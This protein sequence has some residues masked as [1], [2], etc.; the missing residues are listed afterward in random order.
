DIGGGQL[1]SGM[2]LERLHE[3]GNGVGKPSGAVVTDAFVKVAHDIH[4]VGKTLLGVVVKH[5]INAHGLGLALHQN[6]VDSAD[7][8]GPAQSAEGIFADEDLRR[9]SLAGAFESGRQIH[10]V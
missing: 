5:L 8:I 6:P 3:L 4:Q 7:A 10:A 9:I 2:T 1:V